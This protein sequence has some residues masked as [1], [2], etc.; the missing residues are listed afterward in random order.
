MFGFTPMK[1]TAQQLKRSLTKNN[2][3]GLTSFKVN[4]YDRDY[5]PIAGDEK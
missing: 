1:Y 3:E 4:K 2:K 5:L